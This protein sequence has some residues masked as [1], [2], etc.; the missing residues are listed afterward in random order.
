MP[1]DDTKF[2]TPIVLPFWPKFIMPLASPMSEESQCT[3]KFLRTLEV[4]GKC[5]IP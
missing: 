4:K 1:G 5:A 3:T 2:G